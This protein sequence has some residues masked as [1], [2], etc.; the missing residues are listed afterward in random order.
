MGMR[1]W[2]AGMGK[3]LIYGGPVYGYFLTLRLISF[4]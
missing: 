4:N 2:E 1:T 3:G